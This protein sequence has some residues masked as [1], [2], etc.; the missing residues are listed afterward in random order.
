MFAIKVGVD[1]A[2]DRALSSMETLHKREKDA[3]HGAKAEED[4]AA[5]LESFCRTGHVLM[6]DV[7]SAYGNID[8]I[9]L[10]QSGNIFLI[11]TKGHGGKASLEGQV[12]LVN[13]RPAEKDFIKQTLSNT[14]WLKS[15]LDQITGQDVWINSLIVFA[16]AFVAKPYRAKG[17]TIINKRFLI[18]TLEQMD[19][20]S[21]T[22][23]LWLHADEIK[24]SLQELAV[25]FP[26]MPALG[27][28]LFLNEEIQGPFSEEQIKALVQ[29]NSATKSTLCCVCGTE[30][31]QTIAVLID[32]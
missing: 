8:H 2:S 29:V 16:N 9:V 4:V 11:E 21:K 31:W 19:R 26:S 28:Y 17:I 30:E 23:K 6:H 25:P 14:Y 13:G 18:E 12:I 10:T 20:K 5:L 7:E 15:R 3:L 27:Y 32:T 24:A 1:W 22:S